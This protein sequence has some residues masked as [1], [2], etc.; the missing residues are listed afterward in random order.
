MK[1]GVTLYDI[2]LSNK[3]LYRESLRRLFGMCRRTSTTGRL[4][5]H[6]KVFERKFG[7]ADI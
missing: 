5:T 2:G 4:V 1:K 3:T 6:A 7:Y